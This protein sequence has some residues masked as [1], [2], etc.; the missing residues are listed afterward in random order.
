MIYM[1]FS[2]K[3]KHGEDSQMYGSTW[4]HVD[5]HVGSH[6][7]A[8]KGHPKSTPFCSI[9]VFRRLLKLMAGNGTGTV[10]C[11]KRGEVI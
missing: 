8:G 10:R 3:L 6:Q 4:F 5:H 11:S 1:I 9:A 7:E 2:S